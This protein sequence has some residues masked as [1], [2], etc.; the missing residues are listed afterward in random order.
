MAAEEEKGMRAPHNQHDSNF[1]VIIFAFFFQFNRPL[2]KVHLCGKQRK[3]FMKML[4]NTEIIS[5]LHWFFKFLTAHTH[6]P[7]GKLTV[8]HHPYRFSTFDPDPTQFSKVGPREIQK[9]VLRLLFSLQLSE[10]VNFCLYN[11]IIYAQQGNIIK[12]EKIR[13]TQIKISS[14]DKKKLI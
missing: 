4:V 10:N 12:S 13:Q 14:M 3:G 9:L 2:M 1:C 11:A 8:P 7:Q 5:S 6:Q